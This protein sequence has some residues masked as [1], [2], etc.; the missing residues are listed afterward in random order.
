VPVILENWWCSDRRETDRIEIKRKVD[1]THCE[2]CKACVAERYRP[3]VNGGVVE[4]KKFDI[5]YDARIEQTLKCGEVEGTRKTRANDD[6]VK[7]RGK[8]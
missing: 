4:G 7:T 6:A 3:A 8:A 1:Y 5:N 2:G